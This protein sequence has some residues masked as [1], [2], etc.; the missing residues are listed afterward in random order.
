MA[1]AVTTVVAGCGT[2]VSSPTVG[3]HGGVIAVVAAENFWGSLAA[4]VGGR[5]VQVT[6]LIADPNA[7]PHSYEPTTSDGRKVAEAA[8][9]ID[10]GVG[11]DS[12]APKLLSSDPAK[13]TVLDVGH[14]LALK[15][16]A[17]P[18][19]WYNPT[20]VQRVIAG[21]VADY[22]RIDPTDAGYF[23]DQ[24]ARFERTGLAAYH[25]LIAQIRERFG[26]TPVGA[27]E[28]IFSML[29]PTLGLDVITPSSF[30][31]A[32]SEG[33]DVSAADKTAIDNQIKGHQI[34]VY[35][36]NAQNTTPDV[37]VQLAECR[38][39]GIPTATI[40]ETLTPA[41]ATYQAWQSRQLQGILDALD[42]AAR[43]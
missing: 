39:A 14:L 36:S 5:H 32:I 4:Q 1:T 26:G 40:T 18:H 20:D 42:K 23:Q 30:L 6:N 11:Y 27:S 22:S 17:N 19:R 2:T 9:I 7:D 43:P 16:G 3:A 28:S 13:R 37:N 38:A 8:M 34:K 33:I 24:A 10:N 12:W 41:G 25:S 31:K 15:D 35:V 21:L 29:A